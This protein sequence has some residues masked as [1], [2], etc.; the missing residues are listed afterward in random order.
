MMDTMAENERE[1]M[2]RRA[3]DARLLAVEQCEQLP[4]HVKQNVSYVAANTDPLNSD[5]DDEFDSDDSEDSYR[6]SEAFTDPTYDFLHYDTEPMSGLDAEE[7][8]ENTKQRRA[9]TK[10][11][12]EQPPPVLAKF[13]SENRHSQKYTIRSGDEGRGE[14]GGKREVVVVQAEGFQILCLLF[15]MLPLTHML[16]NLITL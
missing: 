16:M 3:R 1:K 14:E 2:E 10:R 12:R 8:R 15:L 6:L 13:N 5:S 4:R 11:P 9:F 7:F